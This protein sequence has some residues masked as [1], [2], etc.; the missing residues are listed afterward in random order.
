M[1]FQRSD[2]TALS[3]FTLLTS[4][5]ALRISVSEALRLHAAHLPSGHM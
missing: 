2:T 1:I 3:G 4:K 5:S